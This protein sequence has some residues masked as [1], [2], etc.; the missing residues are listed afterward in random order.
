MNIICRL[1]EESDPPQI[2]KTNIGLSG[3][4]I[5][6]EL[7]PTYVRERRVF[8]AEVDGEITSVLYWENNFVSDPD[9]WFIHQI[10]T[11]TKWRRKGVATKLIR[12]FLKYV[13]SNNVKKVFADVRETNPKSQGLM[14]KLGAIE[15]G[16]LKGL[17]NDS[18]KD[19]YD[20]EADVWKIYRFDLN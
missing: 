4:I 17:D 9:F 7:L 3:K 14:K 8:C 16:W 12:E 15:C 20:P 18:D 6:E 2:F 10:T 13:V 11:A 1:A 5:D 19:G